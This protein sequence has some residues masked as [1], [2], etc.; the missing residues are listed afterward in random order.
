VKAIP[1]FEHVRVPE[2]R[3]GE[4][5]SSDPL[6]AVQAGVDQKK[7][8]FSEKSVIRGTGWPVN[9]SRCGG[10]LRDRKEP[11]LAANRRDG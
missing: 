8:S 3:W 5:E 6:N 1:D 9:E 10:D 7:G 11:P 4:Q 2:V